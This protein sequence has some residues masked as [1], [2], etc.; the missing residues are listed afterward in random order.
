ML[1]RIKTID[2]NNSVGPH[3]TVYTRFDLILY[4]DRNS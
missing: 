1:R 2:I 4:D 3:I